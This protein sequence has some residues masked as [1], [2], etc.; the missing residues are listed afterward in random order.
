[1]TVVQE[2]CGPDI[3]P[4]TPPDMPLSAGASLPPKGHY[5][6]DPQETGRGEGDLHYRELHRGGCYTTNPFQTQNLFDE[7][8]EVEAYMEEEVSS[9]HQPQKYQI[10]TGGGRG[11]EHPDSPH[12]MLSMIPEEDIES[13]D[14]SQKSHDSRQYRSHE[15]SPV[16]DIQSKADSGCGVGSVTT[17]PLP[18]SPRVVEAWR[19]EE[20]PWYHQESSHDVWQTT[21]AYT[22]RGHGEWSNDVSQNHRQL[23]KVLVTEQVVP[24]LQVS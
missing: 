11:L 2:G 24:V 17:P 12:S 8:T 13:C 4:A 16:S 7:S 19:N 21:P 1:M 10:R 20:V 5:H 18:P 22:P 3:G 15:Q 9:D 14:L 23:R 6:E